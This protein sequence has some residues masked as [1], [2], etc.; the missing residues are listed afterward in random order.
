MT[1]KWPAQWLHPHWI[2]IGSPFWGRWR[3]PEHG[4][5]ECCSKERSRR[6][7]VHQPCVSRSSAQ[8]LA[9]REAPRQDARGTQSSPFG[10]A[11]WNFPRFGTCVGGYFIGG[12]FKILDVAQNN[13]ANSTVATKTRL[14]TTLLFENHP[15]WNHALRKSYIMLYYYIILHIM[16][17]YIYIYYICVYYIYIY[18][19]IYTIYMYMYILIIIIII[20]RGVA[21]RSRPDGGGARDETSGRGEQLPRRCAR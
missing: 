20:P 15:L 17:I 12:G 18:I 3:N 11:A 21:R 8:R 7:A 4:L 13:M 16:Y 5:L 9:R 1:L 14:A 10:R 2:L 6:F 19:C